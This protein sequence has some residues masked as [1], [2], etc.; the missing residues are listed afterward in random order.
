MKSRLSIGGRPCI[1]LT[2][3]GMYL[4]RHMSDNQLYRSTIKLIS[5]ID[6]NNAHITWRIVDVVAN[7][8]C[9]SAA[10]KLYSDL[11]NK[12]LEVHKKKKRILFMP[13]KKGS[14]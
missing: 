4:G 2:T 14:A 9:E 1:F 7:K 5:E 6:K 10:R 12:I 3:V 11:Q 8:M 13:D